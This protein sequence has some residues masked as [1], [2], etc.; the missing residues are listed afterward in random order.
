MT[1]VTR[2]GRNVALSPRFWENF[3]KKWRGFKGRCRGIEEVPVVFSG[4][5]AVERLLTINK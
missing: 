3:G 1:K 4:D 2:R 5:L